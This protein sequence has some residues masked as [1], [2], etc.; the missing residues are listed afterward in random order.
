MASPLHSPTPAIVDEKPAP[1]Q[2]REIAQILLEGF[3][4]HY[5]LFRECARAA[6]RY[7]EAGNWLAIHHLG[8]DRIDFYDRRVHETSERILQEFGFASLDSAE[9]DALWEQVKLHFIGLL[10][11]HKQPECAE[12]FFNS[13]SVKA[14][15][16]GYFHN[17]L[18]F[19]R[20]ALSIEYID[21]DPPSYRSYYPLQQGL[22]HALID[23]VLD[24][25][26]DLPFAD[27][28]R[29]LRN[30][31]AAFRV[32]APRPF[33]LEANHQIQVLSSPFFRNQT[34]YLVGRV[35][36]GVHTFPFA[37][38]IK[39]DAQGKLYVDALLMDEID[40][41]LLFS[42][43]R[44]YFLV[45]MEVPAAYVAFL[46]AIV[47]DKTAAEFY[48]MVGLAKGSKNMFFRDFL[49]HLKHSRDKFVI[50]PGIRGL[51]MTV[52]TLPSYPYVFK[53]IRDK[54]AASK[55][56]DR[57]KV[58]EKYW[59]VKHHD[60]V[61]RMTDTLEYSDVAFP[62]DRF[63]DELIAELT[64]VAA[65]E[66][67]FTADHIVVKHLYIERRVIPLNLYLEDA[68]DAQRLHAMREYGEA[69]REL[70]AVNIFPGDLL[71][72]NFGV[73]R[74]G[75]IVFYDYDEIEY[76]VDCNFRAIPP[77]PPNWD[78]MSDEIWYTVGR[79]DIFPEE[80]GNF[81]FT[82][83]KTRECFRAFH[84]DLL[85]PRWWQEMQN[86]IRSGRLVEV[87]SYSDAVRFSHP[88]I[89][90]GRQPATPSARASA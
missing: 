16:R 74:F 69:I 68:D 4:K 10:P 23:I 25:H 43:N 39:H 18:I 52:F 76:L 3:D 37:V 30:L 41:A 44:A 33:R 6:K 56:T 70:A 54:I 5:A 24:F 55:D 19:I 38:P 48:A 81:L 40:L 64:A 85:D 46:S 7:F 2:V 58:L 79:H 42:A 17:R 88:G 15:R 80:F 60:R 62:R 67:E 77:Q 21:A 12:T 82:D 73:T 57:Q 49:H 63:S 35:V 72:K 50:A 27:F 13:V 14:L 78:E 84:A 61:G 83:A 32:R 26:F 86:E 51:V 34:A 71:S 1:Q 89:P 36:N 47:A 28:G 45:D 66:I 87:L 31:L 53:V 22:R 8:R 90:G 59:L 29:D 65:S 75:R 20:P 9:A 11:D